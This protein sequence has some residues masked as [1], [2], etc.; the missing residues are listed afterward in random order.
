MSR[1]KPKVMEAWSQH[2]HFVQVGDRL[3]LMVRA[4]FAANTAASLTARGVPTASLLAV[5]S[6]LTNNFWQTFYG[7]AVDKTNKL[8][9]VL[10][11]KGLL[12]AGGVIAVALAELQEELIGVYAKVHNHPVRDLGDDPFRA[13]VFEATL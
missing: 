10:E 5:K 2:L 8:R 12:E 3:T 1:K 6:D 11:A 7:P 13:A 9:E 4:T